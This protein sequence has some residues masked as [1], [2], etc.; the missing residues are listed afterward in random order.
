MHIIANQLTTKWITTLDGV[1]V[2][3]CWE[4]DEDAGFVVCHQRDEHGQFVINREV[5]ETVKEKRFGVVKVTDTGE[6]RG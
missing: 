3:D 4:A 1:V 6:P 5:G 2:K